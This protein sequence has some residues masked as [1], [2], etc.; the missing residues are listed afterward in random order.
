ML[1][2][3]FALAL[4]ASIRGWFPYSVGVFAL[5]YLLTAMDGNA[6]AAATGVSLFGLAL[7]AG[8]LLDWVCGAALASMIAYPRRS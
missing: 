3:L 7:S 2:A 5:P 4:L 8:S 1:L 6:V